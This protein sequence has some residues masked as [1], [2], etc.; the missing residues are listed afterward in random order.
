MKYK[1]NWKNKD[2]F[3]YDHYSHQLLNHSRT[4]Y[5][6][7]DSNSKAAVKYHGVLW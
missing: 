3:V 2:L 6:T 7:K 5:K 1:V 4:T